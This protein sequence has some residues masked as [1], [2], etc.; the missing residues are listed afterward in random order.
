MQTGQVWSAGHQPVCQPA[1]DYEVVF[2]ADKALLRERDGDIETLLEIAVSPEQL[3]EVRRVTL[4]NHGSQPRELELTSYLEPVING[5]GIDLSHPP[6]ASYFWKPSC[7]PD[8]ILCSAGDVHEQARNSRS[9]Q[10][11]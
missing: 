1:D 4:S 10:F 11:T 5:Y 9:G 2:S 7:C 6:T 8:R 3:A